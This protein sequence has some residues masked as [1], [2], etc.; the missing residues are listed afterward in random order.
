MKLKSA[1]SRPGRPRQLGESLKPLPSGQDKVR[2]VRSM[3]DSIAPR[4]DLVNRVM[5]LGMDLGWRKKAVL[6]L[7]VPKGSLVLDVACGTGDFC[8]QLLKSGYRAVGFDLSAG[9]L[10]SA[11]TQAPLVL[12]DALRL[13]VG[14]G[15]ADAVT[16]GFALRNVSDLGLLFDEFAR[17]TRPGGRLALLEVAEPSGI[18]VKGAHHFYFHRMVPLIGGLLSDSEAYRYLPQSTQYLPQPS[19]LVAMLKERHF[20]SVIRKAVGF[21]GAQLIWATSD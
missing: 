20:Q 5:T 2:V 13:P 16:C 14:D 6:G 9:M 3:F 17:V 12:A 7:K 21:G 8:R 11:R 19:E 1:S 18:F 4:Y 15:A 10:A